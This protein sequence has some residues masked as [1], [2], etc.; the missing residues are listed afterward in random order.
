M[1]KL[2]YIGVV[3]LLVCMTGLAMAQSVN[4]TED[5]IVA[6]AESTESDVDVNELVFGHI[7]DAYEWHIATFGKTIVSIPLPVIVHSS[8][9]WHVFS[10]SHLEEGASY[11][12]LYIAHGGTYDG[13]IVEKNTAGEEIRPLDISITK[14]VLGLFINSAILLIVM[15]SCVDWYK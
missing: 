10:S 4:S 6:N 1:K 5:G 13:K 3:L 7:G 14:N 2:R 15:M 9:G 11:E 12:G 8:T